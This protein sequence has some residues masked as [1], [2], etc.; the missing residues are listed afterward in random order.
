M[1]LKIQPQQTMCP[2]PS[3]SRFA[4]TSS[5]LRTAQRPLEEKTADWE[6]SVFFCSRVESAQMVV[7]FRCKT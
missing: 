7:H 4:G 1:S 5:V 3:P 6:G 2:Q